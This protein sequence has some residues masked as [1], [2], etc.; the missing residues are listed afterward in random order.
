[1][2]GRRLREAVQDTIISN[3]GPEN[4]KPVLTGHSNVYTNYIATPEE[5]QVSSQD[6]SVMT[7]RFLNSVAAIRRRVNHLW[8]P[9]SQSLHK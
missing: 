1:M 4:T 5:Y 6:V 9:N 8:A 3:G 7:V 2:S